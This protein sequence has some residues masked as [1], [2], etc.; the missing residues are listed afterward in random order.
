MRG[1]LPRKL[2][3][4]GAFVCG[5]FVLDP[6]FVYLKEKYLETLRIYKV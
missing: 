4:E 3:S 1:L 6:V 5:I 2:L